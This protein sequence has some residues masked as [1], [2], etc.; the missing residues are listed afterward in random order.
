MQPS[1]SRRSVLRA[2][3]VT[4]VAGVIAPWS[5]AAAAP[6]WDQLRRGLAG[7]L[8]LPA[9]A[10]Y[11]VAKQL[12]SQQFD[13]V[14]PAA[15]AYCA[16]AEDVSTCVKFAG[17]N[18]IRA[19]AR[20]GGHSSAGWSTVP[21][22]LVIDLSRL[23]QVSFDGSCLEVGA[24]TR[25]VDLVD[26]A[27]RFGVQVVTGLGPTVGH[28]GY[29]QGGGTGYLARA[30]GLGC[31]QLVSA[32]VVLADGRLVRCD[33]TQEPE[34]FWA[35]RGGGGGNFGILT[36]LRERPVSVPVLTTYALTWDLP[37]AVDV[38]GAWQAW[39]ADA[40]PQ[41][42][43]ALG[44]R[45]P[46]G[47][48]AGPAQVVVEGAYAGVQAGC[49]AALDTLVDLV[50]RP[51]T[52]R[53]SG[54]QPFQQ[55]MMS[56][57]GCAD[58]TVAQCHTS[59]T[60]PAGTLYRP[61][62]GVT[63]SLFLR[64]ALPAGGVADALAAYEASPATGQYR[65]LSLFALGG[66][67]G[68]PARTATAFVHRDASAYLS[69]TCNLTVPSPTD[70]DKAAAQGWVDGGYRATLPYSTGE[71]YQNFMDPAL[72]DWPAA[73]YAE[74]YPRLRRAKQAYDPGRFFQFPQAI[75]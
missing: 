60:D 32:D 42:A 5:P 37:D 21:D 55:A 25:S 57:Y 1:I 30:H 3:A 39:I 36:A 61:I 29:T 38:V 71:S 70:A 26:A 66:Q 50:G 48:P 17:D 54:Q 65:Y 40:A 45:P 14:S 4:A 12:F 59:G 34:L 10:G 11:A 44:V 28:A 6:D 2:G 7:S 41:V 33:A 18:R 35:I 75:G 51:A 46:D 19:V 53:T 13:G 56:L 74:N 22:G 43:S 69:Y 31:D 23:R 15:V 16:T 27:A 24:G 58:R 63:R 72:V 9:D 8:V 73:Y 47:D 67:A 49:D 62:F 68:I 20:S 64:A 52:G